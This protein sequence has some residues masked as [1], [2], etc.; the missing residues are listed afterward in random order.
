[1]GAAVRRGGDE[2]E[3]GAACRFQEENKRHMTGSNRMEMMTME[4]TEN[5]VDTVHVERISINDP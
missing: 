5:D 4:K 1:V 2:A 3:E